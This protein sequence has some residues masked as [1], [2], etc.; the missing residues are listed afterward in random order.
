L[1][2][3]AQQ[4]GAGGNDTWTAAQANDILSGGDGSDHLWWGWQRR[5]RTKSYGGTSIDSGDGDDNIQVYADYELCLS[6][7]DTG[8]YTYTRTDSDVTILG[9]AGSGTI[10]GGI[11]GEP[12]SLMRATAMTLS[13]SMVAMLSPAGSRPRPDRA[14]VLL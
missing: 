7:P 4:G 13:V 11:Y 9:G 5:L 6:N 10:T 14:D 3:I 1:T 2:A 12:L 8:D